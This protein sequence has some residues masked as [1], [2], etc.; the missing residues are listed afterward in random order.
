VNLIVGVAIAALVA[1]SP[2]AV[3]STRDCSAGVVR[4]DGWSVM[5]EGQVASDGRIVTAGFV[6]EPPIV[7]VAHVPPERDPPELGF[8]SVLQPKEGRKSDSIFRIQIL[9]AEPSSSANANWT[10]R[11]LADGVELTSGRILWEREF[12]PPNLAQEDKRIRT[13]RYEIEQPSS[14]LLNA[15]DQAREITVVINAPGRDPW[16]VSYGRLRVS[17]VQPIQDEAL[18]LMRQ[19]A[20]GGD[21]HRGA[22]FAFCKAGD[23]AMRPAQPSGPFE[24]PTLPSL[25]ALSPKH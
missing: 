5:A 1:D 15:I 14:K 21:L 18:D 22:T 9:T 4:P 23:R 19:A 12:A 11:L 10:G 3:S 17:V 7:S 16:V 13:G 25:P 2:N 6:S 20:S 8:I 24:L